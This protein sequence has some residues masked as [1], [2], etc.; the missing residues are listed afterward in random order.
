[1][2][3]GS[4][5]SNNQESSIEYHHVGKMMSQRKQQ[6]LKGFL[7]LGVF[8]NTNLAEIILNL[9]TFY[10]KCITDTRKMIMQQKEKRN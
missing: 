7:G 10:V 9:Y 3:M 5:S 8:Q 6:K 1:M 4:N 2:Q